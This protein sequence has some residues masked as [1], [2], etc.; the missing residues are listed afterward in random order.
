MGFRFFVSVLSG[1]VYGKLFDGTGG[2][3]LVPWADFGSWV[4][5][6]ITMGDALQWVFV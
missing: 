6:F 3:C 1:S 2:Y 5:E 4:F